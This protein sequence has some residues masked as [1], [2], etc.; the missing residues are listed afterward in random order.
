VGYVNEDT[1]PRGLILEAMRAVLADRVTYRAALN[2]GG[3]KGSPNLIAA[4]RRF[5]ARRGGPAAEA[6]A[7]R[8]IAVGPSGATSLL[9]SLA[10]VLRPGIVLTSDPVYYIYCNYLGRRG[11]RVAAVPEDGEGI[12]TDLLAEKI[13]ALGRELDRVSFL[14]VVT[15]NNPTGTVLS[16]ARREQLV[17]LGATLSRRLGRRVPVVFDRAYEDLVHDPSVGP[18]QSPLQWDSEGVAYEVGTLSKVLAPALRVGYL[19]GPSGDLMDAVVQRTSDSGFSAPLVMQEVA[20][21]L[22]DHHVAAQIEGVTAGYRE[23]ARA[24]RGRIQS[25]LLS[26]LEGYTGGSAGFYYYLTFR[27]VLTTEGSDFFRF[28]TRTTGNPAI[29]G[30]EGDPMPRVIYVPGEFCVH[31]EGDLVAVGRR[32]LRISYGFEPVDRIE[33]AV[34]TMREAADYALSRMSGAG[35]QPAGLR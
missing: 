5:L 11:F 8:E 32:Q 24:V 29:D 33:D 20:G 1:I 2:Y 28:L 35:R 15:V 21:Y 3:P 22:L 26:Y 6:L 34:R 9:E 4:I 13:D 30:P 23:K 18:L 16:D 10:C 31:P 19:V 17:A 14:Y 27:D 25:D 12:R 7:R